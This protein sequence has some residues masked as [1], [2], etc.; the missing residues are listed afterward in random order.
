MAPWLSWH[1]YTMSPLASW[2][3]G[4]DGIMVPWLWW[5]SGTMAQ[6]SLCHDGSDCIMAPWVSWHYDTMAQLTSWHYGSAWIMASWLSWLYGTVATSWSGFSEP[7]RRTTLLPKLP[8]YNEKKKRNDDYKRYSANNIAQHFV[9]LQDLTIS[10]RANLLL[11]PNSRK[12]TLLPKL[13][14]YNE[15]KK[16]KWWQQEIQCK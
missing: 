15:K 9:T 1:L 16:K 11:M 13:P 5:H 2:H 6:L 8:C 14:C 3:H 12:T 4:S 7:A 10:R